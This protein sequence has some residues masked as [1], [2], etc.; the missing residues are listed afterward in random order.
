LGPSLRSRN[1]VLETT[2]QKMIATSVMLRHVGENPRLEEGVVTACKILRVR[3]RVTRAK[4]SRTVTTSVNATKPER[5]DIV[6][7][8]RGRAGDCRKCIKIL[9]VERVPRSKWNTHLKGIAL[10]LSGNIKQQE[11]PHQSKSNPRSE[12]D[13]IYDNGWTAPNTNTL[14]LIR[15]R[16]TLQPS[17][18]FS[19]YLR[20][21]I[22]QNSSEFTQLI[23]RS[24]P[25]NVV[26]PDYLH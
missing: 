11:I 17:S 9:M 3:S 21:S 6:H 15:I 1:K 14:R 20:N 4:E 10:Q 24:P 25:G 23:R 19:T 22:V 7:H 5:R 2:T 26:R 8:S 13:V 18:G 12:G 16:Q